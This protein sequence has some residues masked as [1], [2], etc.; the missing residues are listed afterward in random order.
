MD[1]SEVYAAELLFGPIRLSRTEASGCPPKK[2]RAP[3]CQTKEALR[4]NGSHGSR[5]KVGAA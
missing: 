4:H 2:Q 5:I 3:G 1:D